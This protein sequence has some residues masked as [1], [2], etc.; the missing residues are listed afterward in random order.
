MAIIECLMIDNFRCIKGATFGLQPKEAESKPL[1]KLVAVIGKNGSGKSTLFD[2][3]GFLSD[4]LNIGVED[5]LDSRGRGGFARVISNGKT[6]NVIGI[7]V[8]F[9]ETFQIY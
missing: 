1:T 9:K 7:E 5:A 4:C 2:V 6:D 8:I 3:I